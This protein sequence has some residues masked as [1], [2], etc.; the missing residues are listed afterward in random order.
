MVAGDFGGHVHETAAA[1][2]VAGLIEGFRP[3][4]N[5][6]F[7]DL[8]FLPVERL[9]L[10]QNRVGD[11]HLADVMQGAR[12]IQILQESLVDKVRVRPRRPSSTASVC[13]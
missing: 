11:G 10:L 1:H 12:A 3:A 2:I 4:K 9:R 6:A 7:H 8:E 13:A 5:V